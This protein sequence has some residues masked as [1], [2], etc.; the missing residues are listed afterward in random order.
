MN[1][2]SLPSDPPVSGHYIFGGKQPPELTFGRAIEGQSTLPIEWEPKTS[3]AT[4]SG[5][6][7]K[8][9]KQPSGDASISRWVSPLRSTC[10]AGFLRD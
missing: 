5:T 2:L 1:T 10:L 8:E 6:S 3:D 9:D 7:L 4:L